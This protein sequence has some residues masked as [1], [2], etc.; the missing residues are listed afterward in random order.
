MSTAAE[1]R[2]LLGVVGI[3]SFKRLC[4]A[5]PKFWIAE[6]VDGLPPTHFQHCHRGGYHQRFYVAVLALGAGFGDSAG[7]ELA[8]HVLR[9]ATGAGTSSWQVVRGFSGS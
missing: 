7:S 9:I 1:Y 5:T 4:H 8:L 6:E 3:S 2:R